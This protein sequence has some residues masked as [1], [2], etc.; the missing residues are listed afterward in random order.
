MDVQRVMEIWDPAGETAGT[1]YLVADHLVLTA[2]H[3]IEHAGSTAARAVEV[4]RLA[5]HGE[6][7]AA[8][9]AAE[10]LWPT[11]PPDIERD[12]HSDAALLLITDSGWQPPVSASPVRW[13]RLPAPSPGAVADRIACV[14]VGFPQAEERDGTRDTKHIGG[15]IETLSGL[16]SGLI[17][18]HID[19]VATPSAAGGRS[20]WSGAS[21]AALFCGNLLTGVL[22]TDRTGNYPGNQLVAV[23]LAT[24][25]GR[26]GFS[27]TVRAAGNPLSL[28][29]ITTRAGGSTVHGLVTVGEPAATSLERAAVQLREDVLSR[30]RHA[31]A[32]LGLQRPSLIEI[33]WKGSSRPVQPSQEVLGVVPEDLHGTVT[34]IPETCRRLPR[35]QLVVLGGPGTGK[36]VA[37]IHLVQDLT[38]NPQPG[39]PVPVLMPLSSWRPAIPLREWIVRQIRQNSP[40]LTD[41]RRF[42]PDPAARLFAASAVMPVLDGLDELP[43]LLRVRAAEAIDRVIPNGCW[44]MVTSRA[45]EYEQVCS[46]GSHLTR[47]AVVELETVGAKAAI[48]YLR[49]SKVSGDDRWNPVFDAMRGEPEST[50]ARTMASPLMLYLAQKTY[51]ARLTQPGELASTTRSREEIEDTLLSRYLPAVYTDDPPSRYGEN[52]ARRY[53]ALLAR[54]MRRDGTADFAWWQLNA[55]LTGPLVGLAFGFVWGWFMEVLFGPVLGVLTGLFAGLGGWA[56]HGLVRAELKQVYVPQRAVHGPKALIRR[57][58]LIG[59][60]TALGVTVATGAG[61]ALWLSEVVQAGAPIARY[62]GAIVGV[63]FGAATLLGSA[64]GSYQAS[65]LWF[66]STGRLPRRPLPF[67]EDAHALGVLRQIGAVY[68]F[69]NERLLSQLAGSAAEKPSRSV[70]GDW[71][72]KWR[73]WR[74][75]LPP[76]ASLAQVGSALVGLALMSMA[77]Y[78][79]TLIGLNYHSGDEPAVRVDGSVC[80]GVPACPGVPIMSWKLPQGATRRTLWLPDSLNDRSFRKWSGTIEAGGCGGGVVEVRLALA[81]EA[82]VAF[83]VKDSAQALMPELPRPVRPRRRP[84][85]LTLRRVDDRPCSL[86]VEWTGPGLVDDGLEP[87]RRRLGVDA[88][89]PGSREAGN[90]R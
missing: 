83:T 75:L 9:A 30:A 55:G 11:Q 71:N 41:R 59:C 82:P 86:L 50:P 6:Q 78:S 31:V 13:G 73:R 1:G 49:Q 57:Y 21:G 34:R 62:Y 54:Q 4:R 88:G 47:A 45:T 10:V 51:R 70:Y 76:F 72:D 24:L 2:Y 14:A 65:R 36:S 28:E 68:Q 16:K 63:A 79:S 18:A 5:P 19:E 61:V 69:R 42:G 74:P 26:P 40:G 48:T 29:D 7:Q 38:E 15:R 25:V 58:R 23:P 53:L 8:W 87:A 77:Y 66:W 46:A 67:L 20:S 44:L 37:A 81:G 17:T 43:E 64:W 22:T 90:G 35:H 56:A 89:A 52:R 32:R 39:D 84:V 80:P 3:N 85:S 60:A 12:P 27:T 33:S